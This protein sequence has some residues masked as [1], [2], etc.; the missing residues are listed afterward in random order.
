MTLPL[1]QEGSKESRALSS[2]QFSASRRRIRALLSIRPIYASA[3]LSGEKKFEFRRQIFAQPVEVVLIYVTRPVG[4]VVAE[5]DVESIISD[6]VA[7]LWQRT[8]HAAGIEEGAFF[9]YF[10]GRQRG[11]AIAIG[12]VRRYGRPFCP[13]VRLG[14]KP[15]QSFVYL[16]LERGQ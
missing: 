16:P 14:V 15:P 3:I 7:S 11:H 12:A 4:R 5:F 10:S 6:S 13:R 2:K 9:D 8:A 1:H